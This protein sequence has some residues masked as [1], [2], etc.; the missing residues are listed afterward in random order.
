[1]ADQL[2]LNAQSSYKNTPKYSFAGRPEHKD[3]KKGMPGPGQYPQVACE[4]DKF[5]SSAKWGFGGGVRDDGK[6]LATFPGPGHYKA[7]VDPRYQAMPRWGF[8]S[9]P[10]LHAAKPMKGPGP[11]HYDVRGNLE[12]GQSSSIASRPEGKSMVSKT[13][14]P[15]HYKTDNGHMATTQ[16]SPAVGFGGGTRGELVVS[17]TPGPGQYELPTSLCGNIFTKMPPKYSIKSRYVPPSSDKTPGPPAA[18][19]TFK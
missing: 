14:G 10:R 4:K 12:G 9:E 15:G 11:G 6:T 8:G 5:G 7:G 19:S 18:G 17:K 1:M 3:K 13:P 2:N 16:S